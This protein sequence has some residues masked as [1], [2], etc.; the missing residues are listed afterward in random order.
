V[1]NK[2]ERPQF[3][4]STQQILLTGTPT[5]L[6]Q[7]WPSHKVHLSLNLHFSNNIAFQTGQELPSPSTVFTRADELLNP[8]RKISPPEEWKHWVC[9]LCKGVNSDGIVVGGQIE[10]DAHLQTRVHRSHVRRLKRKEAFEEWKAKQDIQK[11]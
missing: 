9:E 5:S 2:A 4:S 10:W 7:P 8:T 6:P 3:T 1:H 11:G